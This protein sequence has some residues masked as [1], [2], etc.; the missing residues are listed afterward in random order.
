MN[1]NFIVS[2]CLDCRDIWKLSQM[3]L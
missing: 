3:E 1:K 2:K